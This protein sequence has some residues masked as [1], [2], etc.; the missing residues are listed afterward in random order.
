MRSSRLYK[1]TLG[2]IAHGARKKERREGRSQ[3]GEEGVGNGVLTVLAGNMYSPGASRSRPMT[4]LGYISAAAE[5]PATGWD[6]GSIFWVILGCMW[7]GFVYL[8]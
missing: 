5:R 2:S 6:E 8:L 4:R 7:L 1:D 3:R